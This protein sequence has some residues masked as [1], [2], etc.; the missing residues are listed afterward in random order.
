MSPPSVIVRLPLAAMA[1]VLAALTLVALILASDSEF[2]S[3]G[4]G[5]FAFFAIPVLVAVYYLTQYRKLPFEPWHFFPPRPTPEPTPAPD[6]AAPVTM[7]PSGAEPSADEPFEDPVE[8]ADRLAQEA[9]PEG[10][11]AASQAPEAPSRET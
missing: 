11:S 6:A 10:P 1:A 4:W 8:E 7:T 3:W 9:P 5:R 2:G